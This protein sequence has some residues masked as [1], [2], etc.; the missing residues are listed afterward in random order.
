[1]SAVDDWAYV[2]TLDDIWQGEMCA[3]RVGAG[4]DSV[5]VLLCNVDGTVL[6]YEDKCPHLANPLS[7]GALA[8]GVLTCAAHEWEFDTRT[9]D[10]LNPASATLR[11]YPVRM[12]GD[13]IL[14]DVRCAP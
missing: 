13:R 6:A 10:G 3:V 2:G 12:D 8:D 1:M 7:R 9:G 11:R 14:V 4:P 5:D